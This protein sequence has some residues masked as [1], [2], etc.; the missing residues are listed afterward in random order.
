MS[1]RASISAPSW[2]GRRSAPEVPLIKKAGLF[3]AFSGLEG[4]PFCGLIS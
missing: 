1:L 3:P 4:L 2:Y